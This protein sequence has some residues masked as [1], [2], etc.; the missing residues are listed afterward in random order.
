VGSKD[1]YILSGKEMI[2]CTG[3]IRITEFGNRVAWKQIPNE[4]HSIAACIISY[5]WRAREP[6][7]LVPRGYRGRYFHD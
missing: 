2:T 4:L 5:G 6:P 1:G 3:H 7:S